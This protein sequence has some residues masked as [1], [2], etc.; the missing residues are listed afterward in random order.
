MAKE[1]RPKTFEE[2]LDTPIEDFERPKPLPEGQY[3]CK[4]VNREYTKST[5]KGTDQIEFTL[6]P[7]DVGDDVDSRELKEQGGIGERIL[8]YT[9]WPNDKAGY[10]IKDFFHDCGVKKLP[11]RQAVEEVVGREVIAVVKHRPSQS[12]DML[13]ANVVS[14]LPVE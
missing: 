9:F 12:G 8:R 14:T 2:I 6:K 10:R 13:Y 4:V 3:L 1:A 5:Q 7:I 11:L